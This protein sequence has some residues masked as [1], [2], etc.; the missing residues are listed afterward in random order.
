[1]AARTDKQGYGLAT[2]N[3]FE[4]LSNLDDSEHETDMEFE[5]GNVKEFS[6]MENAIKQLKKF[7]E[8][9]KEIKS[10]EKTLA[11]AKRKH[12]S[13]SESDCESENQTLN[14][15]RKDKEIKN[16]PK[17][18]LRRRNPQ[19]DN[20]Q[21]SNSDMDIQERPKQQRKSNSEERNKVNENAN[22]PQINQNQT[23]NNQIGQRN[24]RRKDF[25]KTAFVE[26]TN[27]D[28]KNVDHPLNLGLL[29]TRIFPKFHSK[30]GYTQR[31][32][33]KEGII[34][35][36]MPLNDFNEDKLKQINKIPGYKKATYRFIQ[37]DQRKSQNK[38]TELNYRVVALGISTSV[39]EKEILE[40]LQGQ[41]K[42]I[43]KVIRLKFGGE[44]TRKVILEFLDKK[45][46]T[47]A[48]KLGIKLYNYH[49]MYR[50]EI[51][52]KSPPVT[53]C[54][55]CFGFHHMS[56][57]CDNKVTC[58]KCGD[59]HETRTCE[60]NQE[61][62]L[63]P[64]C[65]ARGDHAAYSYR[66]PTYQQQI[67]KAQEKQT[68]K[69]LASTKEGKLVNNLVKFKTQEI[70][71]TFESHIQNA[72]EA[73]RRDIISFVN[74]AMIDVAYVLNKD[75]A[76]EVHTIMSRHVDNS[77]PGVNLTIRDPTE[78]PPLQ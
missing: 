72:L 7:P 26:I 66:C 1:M 54:F 8:L 10:I 76:S 60:I 42:T 43:T 64:N 67:K 25:S 28:S 3:S 11:V 78:Y 49:R 69:Q 27:P 24:Y 39:T 37:G 41:T 50:C 12:K 14:K 74:N 53:Q 5:T 68:E 55:K 70:T 18:R 35:V 21:N 31:V 38:Q 33:Q 51:Y 45:D 19:S 22:N 20:V 56:N 32:I 58:G 40:Q 47:E 17:K 63:C 15:L 61:E 16:T 30:N 73:F 77:F 44:P 48:L 52:K 59:Q 57:S 71:G 34:K 4:A 36:V 29:T 6:A 75:T 9:K 46:A 2:R 62:Q 23:G 13:Q 65:Q